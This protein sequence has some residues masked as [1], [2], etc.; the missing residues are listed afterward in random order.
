MHRALVRSDHLLHEGAG[1]QTLLR[2]SSIQDGD[3]MATEDEALTQDIEISPVPPIYG[4]LMTQ[5]SFS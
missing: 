3:M 2:I 4:T 5:A 1:G